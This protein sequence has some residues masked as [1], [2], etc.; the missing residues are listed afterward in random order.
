MR[1]VTTQ[2]THAARSSARDERGQGLVEYAL[3]LAF[4]SLTVTFSLGFLGERI[5]DVFHDAGVALEG[6]PVGQVPA[7][8]SLDVT[9]PLVTMVTPAEGATGVPQNPVY[10]GTCGTAAGDLP[11]VTIVVVHVAGNPDSGSP[12]GPYTTACVAGSWSFTHPGPGGSEGLK[13]N[14]TYQVTVTQSDATGN[15]GSDANVFTR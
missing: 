1:D 3:L 14:R 7:G 2:A 10:S 12:Y 6:V 11:T 5:S 13:N 8:E 4:A 15:T 9:A